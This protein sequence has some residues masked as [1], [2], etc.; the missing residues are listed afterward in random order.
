MVKSSRTVCYASMCAALSSTLVLAAPSSQAPPEKLPVI[1]TWS[2]TITSTETVPNGPEQHSVGV[3]A[4]Q[5]DAVENRSAWVSNRNPYVVDFN[6]M[7]VYFVDGR[8][9]CQYFCK[10]LA[11]TPCNS[12]MDG[13]ALCTYHTLFVLVYSVVNLF[14]WYLGAFVNSCYI[15]IVSRNR[16]KVAMIMRI[17]QSSSERKHFRKGRRIT[18]ISGTLWVSSPWQIMICISQRPRCFRS[19]T[20]ST[21][22]HS[23]KK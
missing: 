3:A 17:V 2:S 13:N 5:Q 14:R 1:L 16:T 23:A 8:Q 19:D 15:L 10:L 4:Y 12:Q 21:C 20:T 6:K 11:E 7:A 18:I 9:T 22:I